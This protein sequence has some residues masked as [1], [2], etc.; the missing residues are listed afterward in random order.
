MEAMSERETNS[1]TCCSAV[2]DYTSVKLLRFDEAC[3]VQQYSHTNETDDVYSP[4]VHI[5]R[6]GWSSGGGTELLLELLQHFI[7]EN[8]GILLPVPM[9]KITACLSHYRC[10]R[11]RFQSRVVCSL[12]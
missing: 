8:R 6:N 10:N 9:P 3:Q 7:I 12:N 1:T 2:A 4:T 11:N 5:Q